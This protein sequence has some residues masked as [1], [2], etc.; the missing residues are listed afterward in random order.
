MTLAACLHASHLDDFVQFWMYL[1][2]IQELWLAIWNQYLTHI[3]GPALL[4]SGHN[5]VGCD[6]CWLVMS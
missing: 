3:E 1:G 5:N 4:Y 6:P 2:F